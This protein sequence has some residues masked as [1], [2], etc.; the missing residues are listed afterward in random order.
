LKSTDDAPLPLFLTQQT[1]HTM[2]ALITMS[3]WLRLGRFY[4]AHPVLG[5]KIVAI[6]LML[7]CDARQRGMGGGGHAAM[8]LDFFFRFLS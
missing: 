4:A 3:H 1:G 8:C 7:V 6:R 2:W 5:P